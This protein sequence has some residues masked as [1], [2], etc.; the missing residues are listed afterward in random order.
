MGYSDE[1]IIALCRQMLKE[2][3]TCSKSMTRYVIEF[4]ACCLANKLCK[5]LGAAGFKDPPLPSSGCFQCLYA[6]HF[7]QGT[8]SLVL[9]TVV[10]QDHEELF[11]ERREIVIPW[12][13][14]SWM[15]LNASRV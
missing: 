14:Q 7:K 4:I 9:V 10:E 3:E 15:W 5:L 12:L 6:H 2:G 8:G 1:K 11:Q 13:Y